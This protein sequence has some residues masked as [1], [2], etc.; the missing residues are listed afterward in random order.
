MF[1]QKPEA[2]RQRHEDKGAAGR[3][4][5]EQDDLPPKSVRA[6]RSPAMSTSKG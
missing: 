2:A 3:Q 1:T 6:L 4:E 5:A